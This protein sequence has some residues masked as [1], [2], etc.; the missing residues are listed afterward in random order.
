MESTEITVTM[1]M[2][3]LYVS[4]LGAVASPIFKTNL[5]R[6]HSFLTWSHRDSEVKQLAW[7]FR[8]PFAS[9]QI[10]LPL[11]AST[12]IRMCI[13]KSPNG[14]NCFRLPD[15][16]SPATWP[17]SSPRPQRFGKTYQL[18]YSYCFLP[19]CLLSQKSRPKSEISFHPLPKDSSLTL[20]M[21]ALDILF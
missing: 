21:Q 11:I 7:V 5:Q 4:R 8:L 16:F 19:R 3:S 6:T 12:L 17:E 15:S 2:E 20:L 14:S 13:F 1:S 10:D 9:L 18:T